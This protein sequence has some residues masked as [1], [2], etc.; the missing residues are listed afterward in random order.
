[1]EKAAYG[2]NLRQRIASQLIRA[3]EGERLPAVREL[4]ALYGTS[5]GLI[6]ETF[7][8]LETEGIVKLARRG[9]QGTYLEDRSLGGLWSV[10]STGPLVIAHTLPSN[11]RYEGLATGMKRLTSQVGVETYLIFIR[12]SKTRLQALRERRCHVAVI[13][14]FAA[15]AMLTDQEQI[16]LTLPPGSFVKSHMLYYRRET[17]KTEGRLRVAVDPTSFD[18]SHLS[19]MEFQGR[20]VDYRDTNFMN[21]YRLLAEGQAD[22]AVWTSD[23][24]QGQVGPVIGEQPLSDHVQAATLGRDASA[25]LVINR[26]DTVVEA[27]LRQVFDINTLLDIQQSVVSGILI[28]EY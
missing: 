11:R 17:F 28:P 15:E 7:T 19:Q 12:G 10:A 14:A 27:L 23:D 18:Q 2:A 25:A 5:V 26:G 22:A 24:M 16:A 6:S 21:I 1:M 9:H 4:A 3:A 13:S 8:S 20:D